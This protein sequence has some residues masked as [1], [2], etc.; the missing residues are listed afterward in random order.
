MFQINDIVVYENG[1]VCTIKEIG[2][3]D[4]VKGNELYYIMEPISDTS[5]K[6]YVKIDNQFIIRPVI[7][8][9]KALGYLAKLREMEGTYNRSDKLRNQEFKDALHSCE[10]DQ[11]LGLM[12]GILGEQNRREAEGK[13]L[14]MSDEKVL[15][16]VNRLLSDELSVACD[17]TKEEAK[18][19]ILN[20]L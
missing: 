6:L 14:N 17:I 3:P 2:T 19:K 9:D 4:F 7:S 8:K 1:G 12:K 18:E 16:R 20:A 5:G 15:Q 10:Y 11:W 13:R